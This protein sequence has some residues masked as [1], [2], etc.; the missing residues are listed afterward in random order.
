MSK[1]SQHL[2]INHRSDSRC[3]CRIGDKGGTF[4]VFEGISE[5]FEVEGMTTNSSVLAE[6]EL[7]YRINQKRKL[8][9]DIL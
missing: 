4:A 8:T 5:Y 3:I 6:R 7:L 9:V 2:R 1:Y